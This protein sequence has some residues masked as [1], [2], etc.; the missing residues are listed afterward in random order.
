MGRPGPLC[1]A[2]LRPSGISFA[3]V[4][5][6]DRRKAALEGQYLSARQLPPTNWKIWIG[7]IG[8]RDG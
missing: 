4:L 3:A 1:E 8:E 7:I 2:L 6:A 5:D